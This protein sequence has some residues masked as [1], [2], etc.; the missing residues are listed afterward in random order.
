MRCAILKK[1]IGVAQW[2]TKLV[3]SL[4]KE[5]QRQPATIAEIESELSKKQS[6]FLAADLNCSDEPRSFHPKFVELNYERHEPNPDSR[7][8]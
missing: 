6:E 4:P 8:G 5:S 2:K 7:H 1:P 3:E